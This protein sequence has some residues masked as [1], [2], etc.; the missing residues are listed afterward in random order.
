LTCNSSPSDTKEEVTASNITNL[1]I[2]FTPGKELKEAIKKA[3][4]KAAESLVTA[5]E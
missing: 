2:R 1:N 4:F 3:T 5:S